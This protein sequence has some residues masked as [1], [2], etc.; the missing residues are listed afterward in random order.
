MI[1]EIKKCRSKSRTIISKEK[2][3]ENI[4]SIDDVSLDG[5]KTLDVKEFDNLVDLIIVFGGDGTLLGAARKFINNETPILGINMGTV[6]FLTDVNILLYIIAK[7][8]YKI[9]K[10]L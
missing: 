6:G 1:F 8:H 7:E 9:Q 10:N 2:K 5:V 4:F 3:T